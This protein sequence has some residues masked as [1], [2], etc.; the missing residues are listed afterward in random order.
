[1]TICTRSLARVP[2]HATRAKRAPFIL[3]EHFRLNRQAF[4]RGP[5]YDRYGRWF[6]SK[7]PSH[8][9]LPIVSK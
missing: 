9:V 7:S 8:Y 4:N 1:M 6:K 3:L 2:A 5:A